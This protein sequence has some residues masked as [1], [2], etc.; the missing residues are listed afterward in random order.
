MAFGINIWGRAVGWSNNGE[1]E[2]AVQWAPR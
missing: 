1:A 2:R